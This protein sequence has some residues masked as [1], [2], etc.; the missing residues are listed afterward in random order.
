MGRVTHPPGVFSRW[1]SARLPDTLRASAMGR[2][3]RDR[4]HQT[5]V[6]S[7]TDD[8]RKSLNSPLVDCAASRR[9]SAA[10]PSCFDQEDRS[11]E[12]VLAAPLAPPRFRNGG[13]RHKRVKP[14]RQHTDSLAASALF[15]QLAQERQKVDQI[16]GGVAGKKHGDRVVDLAGDIFGGQPATDVRRMLRQLSA[17]LHAA[18][19]MLTRNTGPCFHCVLPVGHRWPS[20][21]NAQRRWRRARFPIY[22]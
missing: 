15:Q 6:V 10:R 13:R 22:P 8:T 7:G 1:P 16:R 20:H 3:D 14:S 2:I 5:V 9:L 18:A 17:V 19:M 12:N 4:P 11:L 21:G